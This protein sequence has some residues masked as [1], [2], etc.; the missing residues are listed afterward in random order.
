MYFIF[1]RH[2]FMVEEIKFVKY[3]KF[4]DITLRFSNNIN[5]I[6]GANGTCKTSLLHIIS[7]S[8]KMP[9]SSASSTKEEKDCLS[10]I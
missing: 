4:N 3:K 10:Q 2:I 1:A 9:T 8:F 5:V 6:A 7:N